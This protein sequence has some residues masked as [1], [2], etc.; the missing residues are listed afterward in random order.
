MYTARWSSQSL[1]DPCLEFSHTAQ[2]VR[3]SKSHTGINGDNPLE[4]EGNNSLRVRSQNRFQ[5]KTHPLKTQLICFH[6]SNRGQPTR[7]ETIWARSTLSP[8]PQA[9]E[10]RPMEARGYME[11]KKPPGAGEPALRT[12]TNPVGI[13]RG[14]FR[15][16]C[17]PLVEARSSTRQAPPRRIGPAESDSRRPHFRC[18]RPVKLINDSLNRVKVLQLSQK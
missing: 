17:L 15:Q 16:G 13:P 3:T 1:P 14:D 2:N 8:A 11:Q 12:A 9:T 10:F 5:S 6:N 18:P 7:P 4:E